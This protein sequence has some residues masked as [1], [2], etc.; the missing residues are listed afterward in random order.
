MMQV[1]RQAKDERA[2]GKGI[3]FSLDPFALYLV[4]FIRRRSL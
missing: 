1:E 3:D 4:P 2:K